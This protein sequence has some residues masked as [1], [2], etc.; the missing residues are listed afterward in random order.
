MYHM[1][2]IYTHTQLACYTMPRS[3]TSG[4]VCMCG[5]VEEQ[6]KCLCSVQLEKENKDTGAE[7]NRKVQ[8]SQSCSVSAH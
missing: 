7:V 2:Y 1:Y 5:N 8:V 6:S 4:G 3:V